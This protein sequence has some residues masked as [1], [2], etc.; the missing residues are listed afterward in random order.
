MTPRA[1]R[2]AARLDLLCC[3]IPSWY[4]A[5]KMRD[6][7]KSGG[8]TGSVSR[9]IA[10]PQREVRERVQVLVDGV[11]VRTVPLKWLRQQVGLVSQVSA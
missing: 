8:E 1:A 4:V 9:D 10:P 3:D 5:C 7:D 2:R 11:D 6:G